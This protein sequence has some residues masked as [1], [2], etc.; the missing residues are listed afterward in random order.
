MDKDD[1]KKNIRNSLAKEM[2]NGMSQYD[3]ADAYVENQDAQ[4][5]QLISD[6]VK[7]LERMRA[8]FSIF[9]S[10]NGYMGHKGFAFHT[11]LELNLTKDMTD[12]DY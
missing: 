4:R 5:V 11:L 12:R 3:I 2:A 9:C 6:T 1:I 7:Q 8:D 10:E